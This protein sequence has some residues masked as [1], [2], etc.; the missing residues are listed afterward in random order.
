MIDNLEYYDR[1]LFQLINGLHN[2]FFD[3]FMTFVSGTLSWIPFYAIL[4][5]FAIKK[6]KKNWWL[7]ILAI[8][9]LIVIADQTSVKLF[10]EVF[11]RYRPC[12]NLDLQMMVHT[13]NGKCGGLY[14]FVSSHA[15]NVF[16]LATFLS[17][18][19]SKNWVTIALLFWASLISYSRVYLGVHYPAD[20]I[21]GATLG[22]TIGMVIFYVFKKAR[23]KLTLQ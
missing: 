19:F 2:P 18:Y 4:L 1:I 17:W 3:S 16:A 20:V 6:D 13:V 12:H 22:I 15:A 11:K 14:G 7:L 23:L 5:F 8:L 21:G 10:K 9:L